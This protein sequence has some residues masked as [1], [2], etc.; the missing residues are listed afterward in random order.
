MRSN[1]HSG[2]IK[3]YEYPE[4]GWQLKIGNFYGKTF[5]LANGGFANASAGTSPESWNYKDGAFAQLT[6]HFQVF[7][8]DRVPNGWNPE[9][10]NAVEAVL[11]F[12]KALAIN[13]AS[14]VSKTEQLWSGSGRTQVVKDDIFGEMLLGTVRNTTAIWDGGQ[15]AIVE[16]LQTDP[17][18]N[19]FVVVAPVASQGQAIKVNIG[20][21]RSTITQLVSPIT[22]FAS[23]VGFDSSIA[24]K[25]AFLYRL[26]KASETQ[27]PLY[28]LGAGTSQHKLQTNIG[29]EIVGTS[30][31]DVLVD[32]DSGKHFFDGGSQG[33]GEYDVFFANFL[34]TAPDTRIVWNLADR[35]SN[36]KGVDLGNG[37]T[38]VNIESMWLIAGNGNDDIQTYQYSDWVDASGGE[39]FIVNNG[40]R[41]DDYISAGAGNDFILNNVISQPTPQAAVNQDW[42]VGGAGNDVA[43]HDGMGTAQ[44]LR[45]DLVKAGAP[46]F[47]GNGLG[48]DAGFRDLGRLMVTHATQVYG[49]SPADLESGGNAIVFINNSLQ[50]GSTRYSS[51]IE[52]ISVL[53]SDLANDLVLFVGGGVNHG[54]DGSASQADTLAANFY[55]Y[56]NLLDVPGGLNIDLATPDPISFGDSR[57]TGFERLALIGTTHDDVVSGGALADLISGEK[58]NDWLFGGVDSRRDVLA[59][60]AGDDWFLWS[61]DGS[62]VIRGDDSFYF[63]NTNNDIDT[64]YIK[65]DGVSELHGLY[66]DF[67]TKTSFDDALAGVSGADI[68][69][70]PSFNSTDSSADLLLAIRL[71]GEADSNGT[72]VRAVSF[73]GS[74]VNGAFMTYGGIDRT[75]ITASDAYSDL[76]IYEDGATYDGGEAPGGGD[77]DTF[78]ADF[79]TQPV[80][81]DFNIAVA[82]TADG[83]VLNNGVY[84]RGIERAVV[85]AGE[86]DDVLRGGTANDYFDGGGGTDRFWGGAGNDELLGGPGND[87]AYWM[88]DGIDSADGGEGSDVL[89]IAAGTA[90]LGIALSS[91][92]GAFDPTGTVTTFSGETDMLKV[93]TPTGS[94]GE[95]IRSRISSN[96]QSVTY[97]NFESVNVFGQD[98]HDDFILYQGG[99][100]YNGGERA[101]D[102]DVFAG[103]FSS[104]TQDLTVGADPATG[105]SYKDIGNGTFVGEFERLFVRLGSGNDHASGGELDDYID[106]GPGNDDIDG[107]P[108]GRDDLIGG[109][110]DDI[111]SLRLGQFSALDGGPGH[112]T[113]NIQSDDSGLLLVE[114]ND[115]KGAALNGASLTAGNTAS[116]SALTLLFDNVL[117]AGAK[118]FFT[119]QNAG[120]SLTGIEDI[121]VAGGAGNDLLISGAAGGNLAGGAGV[122]LLV[123]RRGADVLLGGSG[124]DVYAFDTDMGDDL[125]AGESLDGGELFFIHHA[126]ADLKF[127][128]VGDDLKITAKGGFVTVANY[129][130]AGGNGLDFTFDTSDFR[131]K[132]DLQSLGGPVRSVTSGLVQVGTNND[133][134][135]DLAAFSSSGSDA[136]TGLAGNDYFVGSPG[137]DVYDG[138]IGLDVMS[139][140]QSATGVT[141]DL[142]AARGLR[143]RCSG[144]CSHQHRD[145]G[146]R[147]RPEYPE[148]RPAGQYAGRW[149]QPRHVVGKRWQ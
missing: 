83:L 119:T 46:V 33:S 57:I 142:Q 9:A 65:A 54:G 23:A 12:R 143:W 8:T 113:A 72:Y 63:A 49:I 17:S 61:N 69:S 104:L 4:D 10:I 133:D 99:V 118:F 41:F 114:V 30:K 149:R 85:L 137:A 77:I 97:Q 80:G 98:A 47:G 28:E 64:L 130:A 60:G 128:A 117:E 107:G 66:Y 32:F 76:L 135:Y 59:G 52:Q 109:S 129:F 92:S 3:E 84:L 11:D 53:G 25:T 27:Y 140:A 105:S 103:N 95:Q 145:S 74:N 51:D 67:H 101:G 6:D 26:N 16:F 73:I 100:S 122:D 62:D 20:L 138:G 93:V 106:G 110:G 42:I 37:V 87:L 111:L 43:I 14:A 126:V 38:V 5:T 39:D 70:K 91:G 112:D 124:R 102:A 15:N 18:G 21:Q 2:P 123:S 24:D 96:A 55:T 35:E 36:A 81:I 148:R 82:S 68:V 48:A 108:G 144:R 90:S 71:V 58:G 7:Y 121:N 116:R 131:G 1:S 40:D 115:S 139:Y 136:Y 50:Q 134:R 120:Y 13:L 44:S 45:L 147:T 146:G 94:P 56:E 78:A 79:R 86:G 89:V 132:K 75:N 125:I 29:A 141:V 22:A 88:S 34:A 127:D 19:N 31:G